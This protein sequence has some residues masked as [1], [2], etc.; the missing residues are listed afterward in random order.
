MS[1]EHHSAHGE[2][3]EIKNDGLAEAGREQLETHRRHTPEHGTED[4]LDRIE[5]AREIINKSEEPAPEPE[6][7]PEASAPKPHIPF[8]DPGQVYA[9]TMRSVQK[10]L[11]P[12]SRTFSKVIHTPIIEKSSE[13]LENTVAR[14]SITLG[15]TLTAL[16]VGSIFYLTAYHYGYMLSG[17]ELL[18]SFIVGALIGIVIE[19]LWRIL[20]RRA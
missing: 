15:A 17:S 12:V 1:A 13:V 4:K 9:D 11:T 10:R 19:G 18:F 20:L 16:S 8:I 6:P 2:R 14:P 5:D 7:T 3:S